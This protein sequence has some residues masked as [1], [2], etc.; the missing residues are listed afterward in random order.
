[1]N[2]LRRITTINHQTRSYLNNGLS[3]N[4]ERY[5]FSLTFISYKSYL[6]HFHWKKQ[7]VRNS[8]LLMF[9]IWLSTFLGNVFRIR[10][11]YYVLQ[12]VSINWVWMIK[13]VIYRQLIRRISSYEERCKYQFICFTYFDVRC[14]YNMFKLELIIS[15]KT[16]NEWK[17]KTRHR[18]RQ[19][20]DFWWCN[21]I[22]LD[23]EI[24][25]V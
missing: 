23:S 13:P 5:M 14:G 4:R 7:K 22:I 16:F 1:M 2:I 9:S 12:G 25:L 3:I 18:N 11:C 21:E 15:W 10:C 17:N 8:K 6:R 24:F 20:K 19:K